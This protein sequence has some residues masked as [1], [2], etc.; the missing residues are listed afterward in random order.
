M[1]QRWKDAWE[2][3][4]DSVKAAACEVLGPYIKDSNC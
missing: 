2:A 3:V 1:M 4:K